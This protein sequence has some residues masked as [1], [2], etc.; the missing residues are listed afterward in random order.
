MN[1][2]EACIKIFCSHVTNSDG[3]VISEKDADCLFCGFDIAE[4]FVEERIFRG[5]VETHGDSPITE[6]IKVT[7]DFCSVNE[8][9][10]LQLEKVMLTVDEKTKHDE[11]EERVES[12]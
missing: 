2:T 4:D 11:F 3:T 10:V 9:S 1:I 7:A 5:L 6:V 12:V 8:V